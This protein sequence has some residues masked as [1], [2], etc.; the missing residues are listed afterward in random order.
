MKVGLGVGVGI[1][2]IGVNVGGT[3]VAVG[4]NGVKVG[5]EVA[6]GGTGV[7]VG[8]IGVAVGGNSVAVGSTGVGVGADAQAVPIRVTKRTKSASPIWTFLICLSPP[9]FSTTRKLCTRNI[10]VGEGFQLR[11][12]GIYLPYDQL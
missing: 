6:V 9:R 3:G 7:G 10:H 12:Q 4:G 8:D 2:G 11:F 1:G 5:M